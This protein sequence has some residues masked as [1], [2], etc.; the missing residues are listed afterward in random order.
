LVRQAHVE[1][2]RRRVDGVRLERLCGVVKVDHLVAEMQGVVAAVEDYVGHAEYGRVELDRAI[3]V[4][5]VDDDVIE[6]GQVHRRSQV[7]GDI[8]SV[9]Y[10]G[11]SGQGR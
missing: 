9:A 8:A 3:D 1:R 6:P 5:R 10:L 2:P 7:V 4:G 11:G